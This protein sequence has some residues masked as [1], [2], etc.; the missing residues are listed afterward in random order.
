VAILRGGLGGLC[1]QIFG[2]PPVC[3]PRCVLNFTFKFVW[4]TH[5]ADNFQKC[6]TECIIAR[7][8]L[9]DNLEAFQ[10]AFNISQRHDK[11]CCF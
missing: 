8:V 2:C 11:L 5:A 1:P 6:I 9:Y 10:T 3:H 4:L 7:N